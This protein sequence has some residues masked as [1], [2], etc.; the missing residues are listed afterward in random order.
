MRS[1]SCKR[2]VAFFFPG[3]HLKQDFIAEEENSWRWL[4]FKVGNFFQQ[5]LDWPFWELKTLGKKTPE[6]KHIL[7]IVLGT[8]IPFWSQN[9]TNLLTQCLIK[10]T[11]I[12]PI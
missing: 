12:C 1:N 8:E 6:P 11:Q 9:L 3:K 7:G 10:A 2:D 5:E 4:P